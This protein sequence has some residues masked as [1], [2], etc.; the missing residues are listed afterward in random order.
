MKKVFRSK[1]DKYFFN[2]I[3]KQEM[4]ENGL[5]QESMGK[6]LDVSDRTI[7]SYVRKQVVPSVDVIIKFCQVFNKKIAVLDRWGDINEF[8]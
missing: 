4:E 6:L 7:S 8:E 2:E 5:T 3:I 1:L